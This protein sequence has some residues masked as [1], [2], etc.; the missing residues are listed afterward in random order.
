MPTDLISKKTRYEFQ[1]QMVGW[2]LREIETEFTHQDLYVAEN[3][4]SN[5]G[6]QRRS[7]IDEYYHA[8]DFSSAQQIHKL[9]RVYESVLA[10]LHRQAENAYS[11]EFEKSTRQKLDTLTR[12]LRRDGFDYVEGQILSLPGGPTYH[13]VLQVADRLD[14]A[15]LRLHIDRIRNSVDSDPAVAIGSAK[16]LVETTCKTILSERQIAHEESPDLPKLVRTVTKELRLTPDD[17]KDAEK[18]TEAMKKLLGSLSA[19]VQ[20]LAELRNLV[21]T[22]HGRDGRARGPRPRHAR[23]AVGAATTLAMFLF[24]THEAQ[25]S[26]SKARAPAS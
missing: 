11:P 4:T 16:E 5:L 22:G 7:L 14:A 20:S 9:L 25:S 6:G 21:G 13:H 15:Q 26:E 2:T 18:T 3:Y 17:V 1:E 24:E 8:I 12:L 23:L 19:A 10:S